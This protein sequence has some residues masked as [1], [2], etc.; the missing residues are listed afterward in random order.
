M[1][2]A[3]LL[4]QSLDFVYASGRDL[5]IIVEHIESNDLILAFII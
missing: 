4:N 1:D 5:P 2:P 3:G